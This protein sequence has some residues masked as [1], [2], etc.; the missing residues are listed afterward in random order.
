MYT[1]SISVG[2]RK[3]IRTAR[4]GEGQEKKREREI[5]RMPDSHEQPYK[6]LYNYPA[7]KLEQ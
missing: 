2:D 4:I 3:D 5:R 1:W 6:K 7:R